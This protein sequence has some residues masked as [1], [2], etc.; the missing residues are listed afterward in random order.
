MK[1]YPSYL[2]HFDINYIILRNVEIFK[3]IYSKSQ[4]I[5]NKNIESLG[6]FYFMK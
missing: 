2:G 6:I 1:E 5:V 4:N 3:N